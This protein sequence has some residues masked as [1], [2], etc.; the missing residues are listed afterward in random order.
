MSARK[1]SRKQ[2]RVPSLRQC[3]NRGFVELK[4]RRIYLG[5]WGAHETEQ[6]YERTIAEWISRRGQLPATS[7]EITV[8]ELCLSYWQH[9][10]EL[11]CP[12]ERYQLLS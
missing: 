1:S 12:H 10:L 11:T 4:G 6:A 7:S 2:A 8:V 3:N 5:P 9:C